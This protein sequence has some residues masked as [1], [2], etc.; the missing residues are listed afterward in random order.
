ML[1]YQ[2]D[3]LPICYYEEDGESVSKPVDVALMG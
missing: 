3:N 2:P 1:C